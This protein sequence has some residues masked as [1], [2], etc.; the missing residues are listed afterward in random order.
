MSNFLYK[1]KY[2]VNISCCRNNNRNNDYYEIH[3]VVKQNADFIEK[4]NRFDFVTLTKEKL[5]HKNG[6]KYDPNIL[7]LGSS[8]MN[9]LSEENTGKVN[10]KLMTDNF[11]YG[12]LVFNSEKSIIMYNRD[13]DNLNSQLI[14]V[15]GY[16]PETEQGVAEV[17][18]ACYEMFEKDIYSDLGFNLN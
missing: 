18:K 7:E 6:L 17:F 10:L 14:I 15:E 16:Y 5:Y 8:H 9:K 11:Y 3:D 4:G 1:D 2:K 13:N 12:S